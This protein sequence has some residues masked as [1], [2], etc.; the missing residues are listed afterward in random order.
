MSHEVAQEER[1]HLWEGRSPARARV[2]RSA[3]C[4]AGR[5][6]LPPAATLSRGRDHMAGSLRVAV[7]S[8]LP[9]S[10]RAPVLPLRHL[11]PLY[12]ANLHSFSSP[13]VHMHKNAK[14]EVSQFTVNPFLCQNLFFRRYI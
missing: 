14:W 10:Q 6:S 9:S 12:H 1:L 4:S 13:S 7:P 11:R 5:C 8:K 3:G 2:P